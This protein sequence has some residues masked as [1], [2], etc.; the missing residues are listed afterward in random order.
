MKTGTSSAAKKQN[1]L[2]QL[3]NAWNLLFGGRAHSSDKRPCP[4]G[5]L[6]GSFN[7]R[8]SFQSHIEIC[9]STTSCY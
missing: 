8:L 4:C 5:D 1:Q 2:P 7:G 6:E 9:E 3:A